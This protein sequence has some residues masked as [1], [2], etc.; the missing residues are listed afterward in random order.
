MADAMLYGVGNLA[1]LAEFDG[2]TIIGGPENRAREGLVTFAL[3]SRPAA[4]LVADL[5]A[6]GVRTHIRKADHYS[7]NILCPLGL[8][9]AVRVSM[10]HY[11]TMEEVTAFLAAM[12][13]IVEQS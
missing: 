6:R 3:E 7:G 2:V 11:N 13:E 4:G 1:G 8:S 10:C 12:K 5:N 9:S